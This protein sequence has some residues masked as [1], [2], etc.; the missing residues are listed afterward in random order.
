MLYILVMDFTQFLMTKGQAQAHM[1]MNN[2]VMCP[3]C[4]NEHV[5]VYHSSSRTPKHLEIGWYT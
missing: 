1:T 3:Q 4:S 2:I 5:E